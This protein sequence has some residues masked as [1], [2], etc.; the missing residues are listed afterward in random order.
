MGQAHCF[1]GMRRVM[2]VSNLVDHTIDQK[3]PPMVPSGKL[4]LRE[5]LAGLSPAKR[6]LLELKL[7]KKK[8]RDNGAKQ[9]IARLPDCASAPLSYNQQG[10]WVLS[11]LMPGTSLYH[12]PTAARLTGV[13]DVPAL[14]RTIDF[15]VARHQALR[16]TFAV[17]DGN[18]MQV[19]A[20]ALSVDLPIFDLSNLP[21]A[22]RQSA[23]RKLLGEEARRPF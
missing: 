10:L 17:V 9:V 20:E 1:S 22:E 16:T 6:S 3:V 14:Q 11:Q 23:A 5:Q 15:I 7:M 2:E 13:L 12:T 18:P 8:R 4:S 19:I 21:E